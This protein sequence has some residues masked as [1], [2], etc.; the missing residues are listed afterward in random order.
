MPLTSMIY[1]DSVNFFSVTFY[2]GLQLATG[3]T[4]VMHMVARE[5]LPEPNSQS[6]HFAAVVVIVVAVAV[7][8]C[9]AAM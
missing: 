1:C 3:R 2:V 7:L 6:E 8:V 9:C 4:T 5:T